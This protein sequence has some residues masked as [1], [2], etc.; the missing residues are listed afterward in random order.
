MLMNMLMIA[1]YIEL[2]D[3][4][5]RV[6]LYLNVPIFYLGTLKVYGILP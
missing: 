5:S 6:N 2:D 3:T 1:S 4:I